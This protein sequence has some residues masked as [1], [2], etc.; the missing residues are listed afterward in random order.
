M[1]KLI[2]L[3]QLLV[4]IVA[5]ILQ[6]LGLIFFMF[7]YLVLRIIGDDTTTNF[8]V[9]VPFRDWHKRWKE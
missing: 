2:L 6:N 1:K 9:Y 7:G 3:L 4:L 5:F 8:T